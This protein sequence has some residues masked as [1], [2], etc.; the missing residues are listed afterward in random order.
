LVQLQISAMLRL[1]KCGSCHTLI[2]NI[3]STPPEC[4]SYTQ[5][6]NNEMRDVISLRNTLWLLIVPHR[7]ALERNWQNI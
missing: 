3:S 7:T 6:V 1:Y 5:Q 2:L 4:L